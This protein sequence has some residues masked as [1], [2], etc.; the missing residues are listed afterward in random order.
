MRPPS[1]AD[2]TGGGGGALAMEHSI[3]FGQYLHRA[4]PTTPVRSST[5]DV[6]LCRSRFTGV[7][8]AAGHH[9]CVSKIKPI[10][11]GFIGYPGYTNR[12]TISGKTYTPSAIKTARSPRAGEEKNAT[13]RRT[14]G[15]K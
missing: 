4:I 13:W 3:T 15:T 11:H 6:S 1:T 7:V 14:Q 8:S 10:C 2:V 12:C 9:L 5:A